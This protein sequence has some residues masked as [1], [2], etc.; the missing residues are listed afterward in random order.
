MRGCDQK[1]DSSPLVRQECKRTQL[2]RK[3]GDRWQPVGLSAES[4]A[5]CNFHMREEERVYVRIINV[6]LSVSTNMI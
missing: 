1:R 2:G 5:A 3:K 4:Y 6:S